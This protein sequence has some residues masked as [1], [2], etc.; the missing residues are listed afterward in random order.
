VSPPR[1]FSS[2]TSAGKD[3]LIGTLLARVEALM[4]ENAELRRRA[5]AAAS[6]PDP[7]VRRDGR[8]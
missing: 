3:A 6:Q 2:L 5:S 7:K 8:T 1:D 4:A